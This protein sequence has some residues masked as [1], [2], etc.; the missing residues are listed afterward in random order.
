LIKKL[1]AIVAVGDEG[2]GQRGQEEK[3]HSAPRHSRG[4]RHHPAFL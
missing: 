4:L 1:L 3:R 2:D